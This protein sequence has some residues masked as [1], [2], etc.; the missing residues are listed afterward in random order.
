MKAT[1]RVPSAF[2]SDAGGPGD[3]ALDRA[4]GWTARQVE[5][6]QT[7]GAQVAALSP[8]GRIAVANLGLADVLGARPVAADTTF[9]VYSVTKT[10]TALAVLQLVEAGR[11]GLEDRMSRHVGDLIANDRGATVRQTLAHRGGWPNP[12]PLA[13]VHLH[14]EDAGFD[15][16]AWLRQVLRRHT[17]HPG[18]PGTHWRYSNLGYLLL[19]EL[20]ARASGMP[21]EQLVRRQIIGRL[22]LRPW[23]HLSFDVPDVARHARGHVRRFGLLNPLLGVFLDRGRYVAGHRGRWL[24]LHPF[25]LNG[26]AYGG[27]VANASGL[28]RY[29]AALRAPTP[30]LDERLRTV[31]LGPPPYSPAL[32]WFEGRLGG[33]RYLA[34][35]G[36]G[37]G[38]YAEI[39]L[40]PDSGQGRVL[41]FNASGLRDRRLIDRLDGPG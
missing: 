23:E 14:D 15:A 35:A 20:A 5:R 37:L 32:G 3:A 11:V 28:A 36:G 26:A 2:Q 34:H 1:Q 16:G 31:L 30:L 9:N 40:Y 41:L 39:R 8:Q 6:G 33:Q 12:L 22:A 27:L 13:W 17:G 29:L 38:Y 21:Y 19:G 18:P 4:Q 25:H 7:P 10:L 24:Q